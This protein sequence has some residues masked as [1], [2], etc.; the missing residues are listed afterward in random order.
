MLNDCAFVST[1]QDTRLT[2]DRK[3]RSGV[4]LAVLAAGTL[5][6]GMNDAEQS[7]ARCAAHAVEDARIACLEGELRRLADAGAGAAP[8]AAPDAGRQVPPEA[9]VASANGALEGADFAEPLASPGDAPDDS[10]FAVQASQPRPER[11]E[12]RRSG[13]DQ[14]GAEQVARRSDTATDTEAPVGATVVAATVV[15]YRR[16]LV[17]LDN[18]QVWRQTNGDRADVVRD[19]RNE[20]TFEV[21]LRRTGLGG[22]RMYIAPLHRTIRVERLK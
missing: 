16:L 15:G 21:E 7:I 9:R 18:G 3:L 20:Q 1:K 5:S 10:E 12:A 11:S 14:L 4:L 2:D 6:A 17:E 22:Y 19:L 13:A 8:G